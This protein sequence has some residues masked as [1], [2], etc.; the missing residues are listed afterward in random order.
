[1]NKTFGY[2]RVS[3]QDQNL[4]LQRESLVKAGATDFIEETASGAKTDSPELLRM[5]EH[6]REGDKIVVWRLDRLA[7]SMKQLIEI[8]E[9]LSERGI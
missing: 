7:R 5:L 1:M 9:D 2:I 4:D 6:A 3:T 8:I